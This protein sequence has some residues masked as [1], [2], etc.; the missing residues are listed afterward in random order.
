M[1]ENPTN[2]N[3]TIQ[4]MRDHIK[5]LTN[6]ISDLKSKNSTTELET[7]LTQLATEKEQLSTKLT[8]LESLAPTLE[9]TKTRLTELEQA[10]Q[11][12]VDKKIEEFPEDKRNEVKAFLDGLTPDKAL[13]KLESLKTLIGTI[14]TPPAANPPT[15]PNINNP[16]NNPPGTP[17]VEDKTQA[18]MELIKKGQNPFGAVQFKKD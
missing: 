5:D 9:T 13:Q 1:S 15:P 11:T 12:Q 3:S 7:K 2:E 14:V 10:L 8:E 17:P 6:Q 16:N 4:Q 18:V